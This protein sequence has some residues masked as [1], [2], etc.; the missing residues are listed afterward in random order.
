MPR[1][2]T[3]VPLKPENARIVSAGDAI[4]HVNLY[5]LVLDLHIQ[6]FQD[7]AM[8]QPTRNRFRNLRLG[9]RRRSFIRGL[10][11]ESANSTSKLRQE[12]PFAEVC[13]QQLN[14]LVAHV[15]FERHNL[16]GA[17]VSADAKREREMS[18]VKSIH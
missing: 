2:S 10:E 12:R 6:Q 8:A 7:N 5:R 15:L 4:L 13:E 9:H 1:A 3:P 18:T 16:S 14:Q 11:N 17:A